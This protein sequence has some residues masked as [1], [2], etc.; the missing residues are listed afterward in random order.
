MR[1]DVQNTLP[2]KKTETAPKKA[3]QL[4]D[5]YRVGALLA[6]AGGYLDVYT[7]ICRGG[8]FANAQTGNIVL[9]GINIAKG[10]FS[11]ALV[12]SLPIAAFAV[13]VLVTEFIRYA[14]GRR[15]WFHWRQIAVAFEFLVL[16]VISLVPAGVADNVVNAAVAFVC[17]VQ[18]DSFREF[19]GHAYTTTMCTG[20]LRPASDR[21][22]AAIVGRDAGALVTSLEYFG[23]IAF[24][25]IGAIVG[26]FAANEFGV[27]SV[28]GACALLL[29][30]FILMFIRPTEESG[31]EK[32]A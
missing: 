1:R 18:V 16:S 15:T 23:I 26:M 20:N 7:Y 12:Y 13:G 9:L 6:A 27:R 29:S 14:A 28:L 31:E 5:S 11:R 8:V 17:S 4:S 19:H 10:D 30:V 3:R 22:F 21:L 25:I 24:F 2:Q 32:E